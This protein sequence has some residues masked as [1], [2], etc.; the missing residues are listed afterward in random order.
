MFENIKNSSNYRWYIFASV[1]IGTFMSTLNAS[2]IN[3]ALPSIARDFGADLKMVQW[4]PLSYILIITSCLLFFGKIADIIGKSRV[5]SWGFIGF[6]I[7]SLFCALSPTIQL[8]IVARIIQ[9]I[10]AAMI[11]A[12]SMG[13]IVDVFPSNE[14]GRALGSVGTIVALGSMSGPPLAG[15]LTGMLGW[16][17]IFFINIPIGLFGL[18][19]SIY[20]LP[21][22]KRKKFISFDIK[23]SILWAL[24]IISFIYGLSMIERV[25]LTPLVKTYIIVGIVCLILFFILEFKIQDPLL[26]IELF[27]NPVFTTGN[28][29]GLL[30]FIAMFSINLFMPFYF[31]E[32]KGIETN[33]VGFLMMAFP[34]AMAIVAP[35]SGY[36][37]DKFGHR[38]LTTTGMGLMALNLFALS[39]ISVTS[40]TP[41]IL[42]SFAVFGASMGLFQSPNNSSVMGVVPK[43]KL[44]IAGGIL[45][46]MRNLGMTLGISLS[47]LLFSY[48]QK[49]YPDLQVEEKFANALGDTFF[50]SGFI[51]LIALV[52][53]FTRAKDKAN[54]KN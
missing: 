4:I 37:S 13:I 46:T 8:L 23:G 32:V 40:P 15:L 2:S 50:Y 10:G 1:S 27:K 45:A 28:I 43:G 29:A 14:R 41:L 9:G 19:G 31:E 47:V 7:G 35:L 34:I 39:R 25:G 6:M 52:L 5:F 3:V 24:G 11:M 48:R 21:K 53:S 42:F 30:S 18:F 49:F 51:A 33:Q 12:N 17:S 54:K 44:G 26:D 36:L 38:L 22:E 20:L 16:P